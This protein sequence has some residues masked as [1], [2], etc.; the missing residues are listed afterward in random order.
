MLMN[1]LCPILGPNIGIQVSACT[2]R[3]DAIKNGG[4]D[5][6]VDAIHDVV[7]RHT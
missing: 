6:D 4:D 1:A 3:A 7:T 5:A 2:V